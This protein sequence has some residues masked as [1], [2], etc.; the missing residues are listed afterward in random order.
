MK[1]VRWYYLLLTAVFIILGIWT[2]I[3]APASKPCLIGYYSHCSFTPAST[4]ICWIIA[5][6]FY[7]IGK[8]RAAKP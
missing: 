3:P 2:L 1:K 7:W 5:G 8:K 6:V 4:I